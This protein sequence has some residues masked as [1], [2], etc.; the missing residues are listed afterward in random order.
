MAAMAV[1]RRHRSKRIA[2]FNHKGG[3]GKTTLTLNVAA[4]VASLGKQVL[5]VDS[6]PQCNLTSYLLEDQVVD[7]LLD[8]SD[9]PHGE[10][11]WSAVKPIVEAS[12]DV[13]NVVAKEL[14][15]DNL[16]LLPGDI[17]LSDFESELNQLWGDCMQR[18][19]KGFRGTSALSAVVNDVSESL[20]IDFVFFDSGPNIGPLNRSILLDCDYL[21]IPAACDVFSVRALKTLGHT[22]ATWIQDWKTILALAPDQVYT[23]PGRPTV[24][25]YIPQRFRVY[26]GSPA[27][28]QS[29]YLYQI[30]RHVKSD[31]VAVLRSID[32]ALADAAPTQLLIGEVKDFSTLV[33]H[34]QEQGVPISEVNAGT[35]DQRADAKTTFTNIARKIIQRTGR[36][37]LE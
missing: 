5:L 12:G 15:V 37:K 22:L 31:V 20:G 3:V 36:R 2:I 33:T 1:R 9:G 28:V 34:S 23:I 8:H 10:T 21:I 4:A 24:I 35:P 11:L 19:V 14:S 26:R 30:E 29:K 17:R 32:P 13:R 27:G 16:Y 18:K 25:G 6:D 7:N